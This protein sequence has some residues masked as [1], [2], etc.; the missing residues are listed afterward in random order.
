MLEKWNLF[1]GLRKI[2]HS[3]AAPTGS[4]SL[5]ILEINYIFCTSHVLFSMYITL[6]RTVYTMTVHSAFYLNIPRI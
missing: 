1:L 6:R 4:I 5:S 2:C 3:F